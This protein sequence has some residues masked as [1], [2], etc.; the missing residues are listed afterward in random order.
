MVLA[1]WHCHL[2]TDAPEAWQPH[3]Q[4]GASLAYEGITEL[5]NSVIYFV[6][7]IVVGVFYILT[8]ILLRFSNNGVAFKYH[9]HGT[10]LEFFWTI[11]P[12][13][14]L[15]FIAF[16]S[17]RLLYLMDEV[18]AP[19][20]SVKILGH[21]W[22]WSYEYGDTR[23]RSSVS[24]GLSYDSYI[25]P[26]RSLDERQLRLLEV[27]EPVVIPTGVHTRFV[28]TST[29]VI[30]SWAI[31]ALRIKLDA[32]PRRL[33]QT[34]T[35]TEHSGSIMGQCSELCGV[36]HRFIPINLVSVPLDDYLAWLVST[37]ND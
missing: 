24:T 32:I 18:V 19:A 15:V 23:E 2:C 4:D 13:L 7:A 28:L 1:L 14:V 22:Y 20:L 25:V 26:T 30:H 33:N 37:L 35:F 21:Q 31:P 10:I 11:A 6:V 5:H 17:F 12:A 16:P 29:D 9:T 8:V 36:Y 27:D 3:F 34:S